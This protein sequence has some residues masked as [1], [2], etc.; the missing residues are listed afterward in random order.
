MRVFLFS[1]LFA[2]AVLCMFGSFRLPTP[3][4]DPTPLKWYTWE[5][6]VALNRTKPKKICVDIYTNWCRYCK[7]MDQSTFPDANVAAY[8]AANFYPVKLN[9]E[10]RE[11]IRFNDETFKYVS[12][13]RGHGV[14]S[15]AYALLDGKMSYPSMVYLNEKYERIMISPGYKEPQDLIKEL[16]FAGEDRYKDTSWEDF[17]DQ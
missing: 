7:M 1:N 8:L 12:D 13:K 16:R 5:E 2:F 15:L 14:H 6:A 10:Q 4:S 3:E 11:D 9:A 17:R